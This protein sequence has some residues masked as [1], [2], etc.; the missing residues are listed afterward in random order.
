MGQIGHLK[1]KPLSNIMQLRH[2]SGPAPNNLPSLKAML[3]QILHLV[4]PIKYHPNI[5]P[6]FMMEAQ[7]L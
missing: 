1:L 2:L 4:H 5:R 7:L 6:L 3:L